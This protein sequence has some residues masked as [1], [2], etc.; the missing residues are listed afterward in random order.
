M[1]YFRIL[2]FI[3]KHGWNVIK[4]LCAGLI[5]VL[6]V[7]L[8]FQAN[9]MLNTNNE[10]YKQELYPHFRTEEK[11]EN[12]D[13]NDHFTDNVIYIRHYS[14][15]FYSLSSSV[16]TYIPF[17]SNGIRYMMPYKGFHTLTQNM[18]DE[19]IIRRH[20]HKNNNLVTLDM[21]E[22]VNQLLQVNGKEGSH[23]YPNSF[24]KVEYQTIFGG[25]EILYFKASDSEK[26]DNETGKK[27]VD[28]LIS[29]YEFNGNNYSFYMD[30]MTVD[31]LYEF[32]TTAL[33]DAFLIQE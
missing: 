7:I 1:N 19:N 16:S 9:V 32:A 8:L 2:N 30:G 33:K 31:L 14:G 28:D 20:S 22:E 17:E 29:N 11:R 4:K 18:L 3:K 24:V 25:Y 26:V 15:N 27:Y 10:I 5:A 23:G 13:E 21:L 12:M 6:S